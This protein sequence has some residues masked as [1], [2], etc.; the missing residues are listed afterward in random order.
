MILQV[1]NICCTADAYVL[2][3][4]KRRVDTEDCFKRVDKMSITVSQLGI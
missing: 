3:T 4:I 1:L 2:F